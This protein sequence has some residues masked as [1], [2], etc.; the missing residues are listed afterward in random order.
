MM[1][2]R[3]LPSEP[4]ARYVHRMNVVQMYAILSAM[5]IE[6]EEKN[7][8]LKVL[9]DQAKMYIRPE[10]WDEERKARMAPEERMLEEG[11]RVSTV[12]DWIS[13]HS[14]AA[15]RLVLPDWLQKVVD[16]IHKKRIQKEGQ[17][18]AQAT[19]QEGEVASL[20]TF[21]VVGEE[22]PM[23]AATDPFGEGQHGS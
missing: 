2:F 20:D 1:Y 21:G 3:I 7:E 17:P 23:A 13:K 10:L 5:N 19:S 18:Q 6:Q 9:V 4:R 12:F 14:R 15:G 8:L 16:K 22:T 11:V